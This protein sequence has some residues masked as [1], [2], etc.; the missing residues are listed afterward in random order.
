MN[1]LITGLLGGIVGSV[2]THWFAGHRDRQKE[3]Q[4]AGKQFREAFLEVEYLLSI[5]HPEHS[6]EYSGSPEGFQHTYPL[7][8][9]FHQRHYE[10]LVRFN[11]YLS[12]SGRD[13]LRKLWE[14]FCC[15]N[16][17]PKQKHATYEEY[18]TATTDL[19]EEWQKRELSLERIKAMFECTW[20]IPIVKGMWYKLP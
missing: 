14:I 13:K 4:D 12:E 7:L 2:I 1:A 8:C 15:Y 9:K 10:A 16:S 5:R 20:L 3:F 17:D 18:K 19:G 11:P 6:K